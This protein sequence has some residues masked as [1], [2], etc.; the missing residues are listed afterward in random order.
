MLLPAL[1]YGSIKNQP[2]S[3]QPKQNICEHKWKLNSEAIL[4]HFMSSACCCTTLN[5]SLWTVK[6]F[7]RWRGQSNPFKQVAGRLTLDIF[8]NVSYSLSFTQGSRSVRL[9][10]PFCH[11]NLLE[12]FFHTPL[13]LR[14]TSWDA[15]VGGSGSL[16]KS[17]T[18]MSLGTWPLSFHVAC[19]GGILKHPPAKKD[20]C[21]ARHSFHFNVLQTDLIFLCHPPSL[22][23]DSA[24]FI[25]S[26]KQKLTLPDQVYT[27][28]WQLIAEMY[29]QITVQ[30]DLSGENLT[31]KSHAVYTTIMFYMIAVSDI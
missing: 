23:M 30:Q 8:E 19:F 14:Q 18:S 5:Y 26:Q 3:I 9:L 13:L 25:L 15:A 10:F 4:L 20:Q 16:W 17:S 24:V 28:K 7:K 22:F 27:L 11:T 2:G 31:L 6:A 29:I 1:L 12:C 21:T